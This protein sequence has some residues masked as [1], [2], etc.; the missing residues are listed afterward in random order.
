M[1]VGQL[2]LLVDEDVPIFTPK[3]ANCFS[4]FSLPH[5]LHFGFSDFFNIKKSKTLPQSLHLYVNM[6]IRSPFVGKY[7]NA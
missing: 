6:G 2:E 7:L 5:F 4:N 3:A 1:P